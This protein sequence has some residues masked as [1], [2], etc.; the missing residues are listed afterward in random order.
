MENA[1][2][3]RSLRRPLAEAAQQGTHVSAA[4]SPLASCEGSLAPHHLS[5]L[6][7]PCEME[8]KCQGWNSKQFCWK[9]K[10]DLFLTSQ[11]RVRWKWIKDLTIRITTRE[12][13]WVICCW[14]TVTPI[15]NGLKHMHFPPRGSET[16]VGLSWV[17]YF[18]VSHD[19]IWDVTR[20]ANIRSRLRKDLFPSSYEY[21]QNS[22]LHW[23]LARSPQ[24][25]AGYW[26]GLLV[27]C[28][29]GPSKMLLPSAADSPS[30]LSW[31][32]TV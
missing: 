20:A 17:F 5:Y 2:G 27:S 13:V 3:E 11:I 16:W 18:R 30:R 23:W 6:T 31:S 26:L 1:V 24:F 25:L 29:R 21:W 22:V 28:N 12:L 8:C 32:F 10:L 19:C 14:V 9:I 4:A 15:Q 7:S